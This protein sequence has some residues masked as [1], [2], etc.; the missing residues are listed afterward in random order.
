VDLVKEAQIK[1]A[2]VR[3]GKGKV[4]KASAASMV[5]GPIARSATSETT[6]GK[7]EAIANSVNLEKADIATSVI[8]VIIASNAIRAISVIH[9]S[10]AITVVATSAMG[11]SVT[12]RSV[13]VPLENQITPIAAMRIVRHK[14][15]EMATPQVEQATLSKASSRERASSVISASH[16]IKENSAIIATVR[17]KIPSRIAIAI[18]SA[19]ARRTN[20]AEAWMAAAV[21]ATTSNVRAALIHSF[22]VTKTSN[23]KQPSSKRQLQT[24]IRARKVRAFRSVSCK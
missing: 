6:Q 9:A 12:T 18:S 1:V 23:A 2:A 4:G 5:A 17:S 8:S 19:E 22:Q 14:A 13:R 3:A 10:I 24:P 15:T 21:G 7:A 16:V 20:A 11:R